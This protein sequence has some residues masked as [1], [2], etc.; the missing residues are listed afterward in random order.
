MKKLLFVCLGLLLMANY[1]A[2]AGKEP[3]VAIDPEAEY[4]LATAVSVTVNFPI[5]AFVQQFRVRTSGTY[6]EI[7]VLDCCIAGDLWAV[8]AINMNGGVQDVRGVCNG[9]AAGYSLPPPTSAYWDN[10]G[11]GRAW[12]SKIGNVEIDA[13]VEFRAT[14]S[15]A[16]SPSSAFARFVSNADVTV[17]TLTA[18]STSFTPPIAPI[19]LP[20]Q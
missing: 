2:A 4:V 17:N 13:L 11:S 10:V 5:D 15:N 14:K 16:V 6:L 19:P 8:R 3:N 20:S 9:Y 12:I 18:N 7:R 1:A